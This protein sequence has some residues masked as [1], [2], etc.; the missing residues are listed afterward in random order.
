MQKIVSFFKNLFAFKTSNKPSAKHPRFKRHFDV[1]NGVLLR[2]SHNVGCVAGSGFWTIDVYNIHH[3]KLGWRTIS[4]KFFTSDT[5]SGEYQSAFFLD[6]ILFS[7]ED[8]NRSRKRILLLESLQRNCADNH[9]DWVFWYVLHVLSEFAGM[10][11]KDENKVEISCVTQVTDMGD[12]FFDAIYATKKELGLDTSS[13]YMQKFQH[14]GAGADV[15]KEVYVIDGTSRFK[16]IGSSAKNML[17]IHWT[18]NLDDIR[19]E[20]GINTKQEK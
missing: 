20:T 19:L 15:M 7:D 8:E 6:R 9:V 3:P 14:S 10:K 18:F 12:E 13:G 2:R 17:E 11:V 16:H 1:A 4:P 5:D